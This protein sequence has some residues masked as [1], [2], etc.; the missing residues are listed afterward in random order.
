MPK[1]AFLYT[2]DFLTYHLSDSHPLQQKRLQMVQ[3][4][5]GSYGLFSPTGAV[6]WIHPQTASD[7][8]IYAIHTPDFIEAVRRASAGERGSFLNRYGLSAGDTPAFDGMYDA[9]KLYCGGSIEAARLVMN[10]YDTAF[11]VSGGLHHAQADH[12]SGF[13]TFN[14]LAMAIRELQQGG[15]RK[16]AYIDIDVHHGDGVQAIFYDD[17]TVMTISLHETGKRLYPGT[18]FPREIGAGDATKTSINLPFAPYTG[19]AVWHKAFDAV[20]PQVLARFE[21]DAF[22]L[23]LGADAHFADPLAHLQLTTQGWMQAVDKLLTLSAGKPTVVTGGGGYNL[24][25]VTRLW[26]LVT[27]RLADTTLPNATPVAFDA[28]YDIPFLHDKPNAAPSVSDAMEAEIRNYAQ[29]QVRELWSL[30]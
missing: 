30:L 23:Q 7:E 1:T 18:G 27:A 10:G 9:A 6:D 26:T 15:Y 28:M 16:V 4:L 25:T 3:R 22:V 12:A 17:P 8:A 2:D 21:P 11:N 29:V 14:D 20:V 5:V 24:K 19:D 13:C